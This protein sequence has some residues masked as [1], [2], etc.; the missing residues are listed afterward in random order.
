MLRVKKL[1]KTTW[2]FQVKKFKHHC[3]NAKVCIIYFLQKK[4]SMP[5]SPARRTGGL[6]VGV[7][8]FP[9]AFCSARASS[10]CFFSCLVSGLYLWASLNSCV[11]V[12]EIENQYINW[13]WDI[14]Q[15]MTCNSKCLK[16]DCCSDSKYNSHL[17]NT[18]QNNSYSRPRKK[19][20]HTNNTR[21]NTAE[22]INA[23]TENYQSGGLVP[24]WTGWSL[25]G[26]S[27]ACTGWSAASAGGCSGAISQSVSNHAL[28]GC[29][30]LWTN[31]GISASNQYRVIRKV[32]SHYSH[33]TSASAIL[34]GCLHCC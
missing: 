33:G 29:P 15:N 30:D 16:L 22:L 18:P 12:R 17:Q 31:M 26:P 19:I 25:G 5:A 10:L 7:S 23:C 24:G 11:A 8:P 2:L 34:V 21:I 6:F 32:K 1:N 13:L 4:T 3:I 28:A 20:T 27:D 9:A 14:A